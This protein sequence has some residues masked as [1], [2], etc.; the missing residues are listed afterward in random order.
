MRKRVLTIRNEQTEQE[1]ASGQAV[2]NFQERP[3]FGRSRSSPSRLIVGGTITVLLII[4]LTGNLG[5]VFWTFVDFTLRH[6]G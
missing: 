3:I 6:G 1:A 2:V 5:E 4:I